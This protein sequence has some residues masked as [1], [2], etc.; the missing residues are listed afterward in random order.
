MCDGDN[1]CGDSSDELLS[2]CSSY[3]CTKENER[4]RCKNGLCIYA[5]NVC[6]GYNDCADGSGIFFSIFKFG[7]KKFKMFI[8]NLIKNYRLNLKIINYIIL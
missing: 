6:N 3:N 4:F 7:S 5:D 2:L 1:D 8:W